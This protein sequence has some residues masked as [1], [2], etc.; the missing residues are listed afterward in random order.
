MVYLEFLQALAAI[1]VYRFPDPYE[2]V[3]HKLQVRPC[4]TAQCTWPDMSTPRGSH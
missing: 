2:P 3:M 1:S 4:V